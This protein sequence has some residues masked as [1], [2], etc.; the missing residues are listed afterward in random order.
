MKRLLKYFNG[1]KKECALAP[2]FKMLEATLELFVPLVVK[3]IIDTGIA[4][5]DR[6]YIT[7]MCLLMAL[8]ALAG[9]LMSVTAQYFAAKAAVGFSCRLRSA[10]FRHI[11]SFGYSEADMLGTPSLITRMTDDINLVQNGVNLTL[12]LLLRSPFVVFGAVIM[13]FTVDARSAVVFAGTVPV[14]SVIVFG[15]MLG[16][17]PLYKT[18]RKKLDG[19]LTDAR[20]ALSGVRVIRA[21]GLEENTEKNF[22][23]KTSEHFSA[24]KKAGRISAL[25]NPLTY[26]LVNTAVIL[27]IYRGAVRVNSGALTQGAVVAL[28]NYMG[29]ILVELIKLADLIISISKA[30]TGAGRIADVLDMTCS[31][32]YPQNSEQPDFDSPAVELNGVSLRYVGSRENAVENICFTARP[33]S[34][35]GIIGAT[36]S[37]KTTV[38]SLIARFYDPAQGEVKVFG[39]NVKEYSAQKLSE[40]VA[41]VPQKAV[42][43]SGTLRD[44]LKWGNENATDEEM[45]SAL[46][47]AQAEDI[48]LSKTNGLDCETEQSGKNF[49]GGQRQRLTIARAL[50]KKSPILILDDSSSA[51]DPATDLRLRR[52]LRTLENAP[53]VV[54]ISQRASAVSSCDNIIVLE[55]GKISAQ[56]THDELMKTCEA[57]SEL[58]ALSEKGGARA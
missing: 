25:M 2:L 5:N 37:G 34:F 32:T 27:L 30:L 26:V 14:L 21:F 20:Q 10:L 45:L 52:S 4:A 56:G 58:Y 29:Q 33:G 9:L 28:Y 49:S 6:T 47:T 3:R 1:L 50:L 41:L 24:E 12:R 11:L 43:F 39:H 36:G 46:K 38:A 19:V 54:I 42:L 35:T 15:I 8:L 18:V 7:R 17:M 23:T 16:T 55:D 40:L 51:L 31:V 13:A 44:N 57:Y 22:R 48:I 53:C